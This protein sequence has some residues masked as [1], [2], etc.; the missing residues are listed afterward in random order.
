MNDADFLAAVLS[1]GK[2]HTTNEIL[3]A[4]FRERGCGLTVH[5]RASDLR[6]KRHLN[7]ACKAAG[8]VDGRNVFEYQ[9]LPGAVLPPPAPENVEAHLLLDSTEAG[10]SLPCSPAATPDGSPA[11]CH[12]SFA[13][14]LSVFEAA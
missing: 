6:N 3:H 11:G 14:Q 7:I 4:S 2:P 10:G 12:P 9:L 13:K 1:D 8:K 5:S